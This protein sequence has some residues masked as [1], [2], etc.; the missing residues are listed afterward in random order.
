MA[1]A[2]LLTELETRLEAL[3][4][5]L[6]SGNGAGLS[7]AREALRATLTRHGLDSGQATELGERILAAFQTGL[8]AGDAP[9]GL[10]KAIA[11]S[12]VNTLESP[13]TQQDNPTQTLER[14]LATGDGVTNLPPSY[15]AALQEALHQGQGAENAASS[16]TRQQEAYV[17]M[18]LRQ[19]VPVDTPD[20][21][22]TGLANGSGEAETAL[23]TLVAGMNREQAGVFMRVFQDAINRGMDL[24]EALALAGAFLNSHD[25]LVAAQ[26]VGLSPAQKLAAALASGKEIDAALAETGLSASDADGFFAALG[27]GADPAQAARD[28]RQ[29]QQAMAL[30]RERHTLPETPADRL[31]QAMAS[32]QDAARA[33]EAGLPG[34]DPQGR[35]AFI[36]TLTRHLELGNA[37]DTALGLARHAAAAA[38]EAARQSDQPLTREEQLV[39]MMATGR[40]LESLVT[41]ESE[42]VLQNFTHALARGEPT[43]TAMTDARE[44]RAALEPYQP[45]AS[46][47]EAPPPPD[48]DGFP[49]APP[50]SPTVIA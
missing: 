31:L 7:A 15:R 23:R 46:S 50:P 48:T 27:N 4:E 44:I 25:Q 24:R 20:G 41:A 18:G 37:P 47:W 19:V 45:V 33:I 11:L 43:M 1:D 35:E 36:A 13:H 30:T 6:A 38:S 49:E 9:A 14:A 29:F 2:P 16:A 34:E 8:G 10:V 21:L 40:N 3:I 17:A 39:A 26:Q 32:G 5:P 42:S 22:A 12:T 28:A